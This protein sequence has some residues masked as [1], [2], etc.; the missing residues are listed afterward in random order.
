M[1]FDETQTW[2]F[3]QSFPLTSE[4]FIILFKVESFHRLNHLDLYQQTNLF[5]GSSVNHT[6]K[7]AMYLFRIKEFVQ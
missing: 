5:R 1:A 6:Q 2:H 7:K 4:T 3:V